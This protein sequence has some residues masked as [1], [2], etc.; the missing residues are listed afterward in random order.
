MK[1]IEL[2]TGTIIVDDDSLTFEWD[3]NNLSI[4]RK[5]IGKV[6]IRTERRM[7]HATWQYGFRLGAIGLVLIIF[8]FIRPSELLSWAGL[9]AMVLALLL[10]I[11]DTLLTLIGVHILDGIM[12]RVMGE[13]VVFATI[14]NTRGKDIEFF[15]SE[16]DKKVVKSLEKYRISKS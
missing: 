11:G 1:K 5:Y 8:M 6:N 3:D 7:K 15:I 10:V 16:S 9:I 12:L 13:D 2:S 14:Q 4:L